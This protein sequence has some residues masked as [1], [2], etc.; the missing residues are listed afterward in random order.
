M[1]LA[2]ISV[3]WTRLTP[4]FYRFVFV[5]A[6]TKEDEPYLADSLFFLPLLPPNYLQRDLDRIAGRVA[7]PV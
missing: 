4:C 3:L 6:S 2:A 7:V 1:T 5:C